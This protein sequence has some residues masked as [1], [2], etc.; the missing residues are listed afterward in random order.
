MP[1]SAI[2]IG[3]KELAQALERMSTTDIPKALK[4]GVRYAARGGR[5]AV[6][7][8]I[9]AHYSLS[10]ARIKQDVSEPS[11]RDGGNT[12]VLT[13]KEK[14]ITA[15]QFKARETRKGL[16]MAIYKGERTVIKSGFIAKGLPFKRTT[17]SRYPLDVVHGPSIGRI[18]RSGRHANAIQDATQ[19]RIQE[20]LEKGVMRAIGKLGAGYLK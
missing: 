10:A 15:M 1:I 9:G 19:K 16:S 14:P 3:D 5:A 8:N 4:A 11:Y 13:L 6:A 7:K 18:Y 12:A 17:K 20:Q 2:V